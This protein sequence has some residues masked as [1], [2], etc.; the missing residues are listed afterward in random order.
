MTAAEIAPLLRKQG[1]RAANG[2]KRDLDA[3]CGKLTERL[4]RI[5]DPLDG[6]DDK[7]DEILTLLKSDQSPKPD[8]R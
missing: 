2:R 4:N 8:P 6:L 3:L 5:D 7:L 1:E